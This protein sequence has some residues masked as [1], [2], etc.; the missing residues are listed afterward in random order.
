MLVWSRAERPGSILTFKNSQTD[1][2]GDSV[3]FLSLREERESAELRPPTWDYDPMG[4]G[5]FWAV[6]N[7]L[8]KRAVLDLLSPKAK[9]ASNIGQCALP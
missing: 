7:V 5:T 4:L 3:L 6:F 9:T 8:G 2:R 1:L